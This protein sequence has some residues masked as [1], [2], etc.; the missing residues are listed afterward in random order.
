MKAYMIHILIDGQIQ[1]Q[2][3]GSGGNGMEAFESAVDSGSV[4][5]PSDRTVDIVAINLATRIMV[6]FEAGMAL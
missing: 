6:K 2:G 3:F 5:L 4:Y 1:M